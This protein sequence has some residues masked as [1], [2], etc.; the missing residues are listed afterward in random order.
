LKVQLQLAT[1]DGGINGAERMPTRRTMISSVPMAATLLSAS[2]PADADDVH[3]SRALIDR[4]AAAWLAG[5]TS[6]CIACYHDR[7]TLHYFGR[8]ALS[9][10][11]TG[12]SEALIA[13][14]E[15][16]LRTRWR[17]VAIKATLVGP[18]HVAIVASVEYGPQQRRVRRD[19]VLVFT[20]EDS[21]LRECWAYDQ[22]QQLMD[23]LIG[24]AA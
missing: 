21:L 13:L 20:I 14:R 5:D 7:F 19:R 24:P 6:T 8:N 4:Y 23:Q 9:G 16:G 17:P 3:A 15:M 11:H 10:D 1:D 22:D 12:K 2:A 18:D